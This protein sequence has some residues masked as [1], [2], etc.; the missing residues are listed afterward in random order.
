MD[1]E[2]DEDNQE[3]W[4]E[5]QPRK[6]TEEEKIKKKMWKLLNREFHEF[7]KSVRSKHYDP[8]DLKNKVGFLVNDYLKINVEEQDKLI[9]LGFNRH[10]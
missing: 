8:S 5:I 2:S 4:G 3:I 9:L 10:I 1:L 7:K 6:L